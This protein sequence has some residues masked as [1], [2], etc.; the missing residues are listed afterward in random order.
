MAR[1]GLDRL[2]IVNTVAGPHKI[3]ALAELA[4]GVD[5]MVAVDDA[6]NAETSRTLRGRG[7]VAR[8]GS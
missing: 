1:A 8:S 3:R 4:R 5:L 6:G 7:R 2:F